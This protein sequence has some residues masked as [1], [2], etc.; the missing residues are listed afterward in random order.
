MTLNRRSFRRELAAHRAPS[1]IAG[2]QVFTFKH[3][4]RPKWQ[5]WGAR[6]AGFPGFH[7]VKRGE[8]GAEQDCFRLFSFSGRAFPDTEF[9]PLSRASRQ[10][11][12]RQRRFA[13]GCFFGC[14][15]LPLSR[16]SRQPPVQQR[17]HAP[18]HRLRWPRQPASSASTTKT[19]LFAPDGAL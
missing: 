8:H 5:L 7:T 2:L 11:P 9:L 4:L 3:W 10:P 19:R 6:H 12:V 17:A 16:A 18:Q 14:L 1:P 13:C 15:F